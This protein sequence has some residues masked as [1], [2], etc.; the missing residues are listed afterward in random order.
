[1]FSKQTTYAHLNNTEGTFMSVFSI[2]NYFSFNSIH[3]LFRAYFHVSAFLSLLLNFLLKT[4]NLDYEKLDDIEVLQC[5]KMVSKEN[6]KW[7]TVQD[8]PLHSEN[9]WPDPE[10][11]ILAS[12][13][14]IITPLSLFIVLLLPMMWKIL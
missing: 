14:S 10:S 5:N 2:S 12:S 7:K 11:I 3:K 1:M 4:Y 9:S 6:L 8:P 13:L